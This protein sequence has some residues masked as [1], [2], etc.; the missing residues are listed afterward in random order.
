MS[1]FSRFFA[2]RV[3]K[4]RRSLAPTTTSF[5]NP[6]GKGNRKKQRTILNL[7]HLEDRCVPSNL[8]YQVTSSADTNDFTPTSGGGYGTLRGCITAAQGN[9]SSGSTNFIQLQT[10]VNVTAQE[11]L[12]N[13]TITISGAWNNQREFVSANATSLNPYNIFRVT[14]TGIVRF[15]NIEIKG[16]YSTAASGGA[17]DNGGTLTLATVLL[18]RNTGNYGGALVNDLGAKCTISQSG[19]NNNT[20]NTSGGGIDNDG[21][22]TFTGGACTISNNSTSSGAGNGGGIYNITGT[23]TI[24]CTMSIHDNHAGH[25]SGAGGG[26]YTIGSGTTTQGVIKMG[27]QGSVSDASNDAFKGAGIC[28][29]TNTTTDLTNWTF[30][31]NVAGSQGGAAFIY[32]TS[33]TTFGNTKFGVTGVLDTANGG[34]NQSDG[35]GGFFLT[36]AVFNNLAGL[37]DIDDPLHHMQQG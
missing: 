10:F 3:R 32:A 1:L 17:I 26:V 4:Q 25:T 6:K 12:L 31:G 2:S 21:K 29:V 14:A 19:F 15:E 23:L 36:G 27:S 28:I 9:S 8:M 13:D 22:M 11:P 20:A 30:K 16:G 24:N 5:Q 33:T 37:T 7:E 18:D 34:N 35:P